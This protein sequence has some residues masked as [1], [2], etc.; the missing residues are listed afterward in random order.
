MPKTVS[1][2]QTTLKEPD[3]IAPKPGTC[4]C[5]DYEWAHGYDDDSLLGDYY[6]CSNCGELTQ[7][8]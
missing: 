5:S 8:G 1:K 3:H 7:V 4:N 2:R 6:Y